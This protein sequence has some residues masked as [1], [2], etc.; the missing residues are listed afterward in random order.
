MQFFAGSRK[1]LW[2]PAFGV[3]S[4]KCQSEILGTGMHLQLM[5][6]VQFK[7]SSRQCWNCENLNSGTV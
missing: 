5:P 6:C 3:P 7:A 4:C 1:W 2:F